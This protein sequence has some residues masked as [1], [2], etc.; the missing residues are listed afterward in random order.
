LNSQSF[1]VY[2]SHPTNEFLGRKRVER[3]SLKRGRRLVI[4]A[5]RLAFSVQRSAVWRSVC[6]L[7]ALTPVG[8]PTK[9]RLQ[10][11]L[12][13]RELLIF[14]ANINKCEYLLGQFTL[15]VRLN[16]VFFFECLY[17]FHMC[18]DLRVCMCVCF[19]GTAI[20]FKV[21]KKTNR[22]RRKNG[23][24]FALQICWEKLKKNSNKQRRRI[25]PSLMWLSLLPILL[26][27]H[28][29]QPTHPNKT[30]K[31]KTNQSPKQEFN[32]SLFF[33]I[34]FLLFPRGI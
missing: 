10:N 17:I 4:C 23:F 22:E 32:I 19:S 33:D 13:A 14:T 7:H 34:F 29:H 1:G 16:S 11:R 2:D 21:I 24:A 3:S 20:K 28:D 26:G 12:T 15:K 31:T 18:Q 25:L 5:R 6:H 9:T 27:D 30:N 8:P